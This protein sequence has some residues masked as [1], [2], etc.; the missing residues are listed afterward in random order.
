MTIR[1]AAARGLAGAS[2]E[3]F[4]GDPRRAIFDLDL[5]VE[6]IAAAAEAAAALDRDFVLTARAENFLHGRPDLDDTIRRLRAFDAA[7]ADVLYAPG[8]RDLDQIR[9]ICEATSKPVNV[10]MGLPGVTFDVAQL[11]AV[12]VKRINVGSPSRGWR[13]AG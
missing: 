4:S 9:T 7:G 2:I 11:A 3:D 12:G 10:I 8:L 5:A 6:R 13:M 1:Q